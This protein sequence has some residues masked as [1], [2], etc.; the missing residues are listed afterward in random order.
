MELP[1]SAANEW[2][3]YPSTAESE[4]W[5]VGRSVEGATLRRGWRMGIDGT[6]GFVYCGAEDVGI[7]V[8]TVTGSSVTGR[9]FAGGS[10]VGTA[11]ENTDG[12]ID[13]KLSFHVPA[14]VGLVQGTAPQALPY[15]KAVEGKYPPLF[16]DGEPVEASM[17]PVKIMVKKLPAT[18][19]LPGLLGVGWVPSV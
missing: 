5:P 8:F 18:S 9:D 4:D 19:A 16:G 14:G 15:T 7:G 1:L 17:P 11:T 3:I 10:Y 13:L 2:A 12:T 6:Y